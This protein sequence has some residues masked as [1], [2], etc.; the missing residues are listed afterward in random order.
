MDLLKNFEFEINKADRGLTEILKTK[1]FK[2]EKIN[3]SFFNL[4]LLNNCVSYR[5]KFL[6]LNEMY[7]IYLLANFNSS[8]YSLST[9]KSLLSVIRNYRIAIFK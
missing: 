5:K 6:T 4:T 8:T 3:K 9:Y 7:K 1:F 2:V